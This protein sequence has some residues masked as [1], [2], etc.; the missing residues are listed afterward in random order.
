MKIKKAQRKYGNLVK[1]IA[2][3][4]A[5]PGH[6]RLS[7]EDLHAEGMLVLVRCC[8]DLP[9]GTTHFGKYFKRSLYNKIQTLYRFEKELKR[10][11]YNV[12]LDAATNLPALRE[13]G[14][15]FYA[16]VVLRLLPR[17]SSKSARL[18]ETLVFPPIGLFD[19][20]YARFLRKRTKNFRVKRS[21]IHGF[22]GMSKYDVKLAIQEVRDVQLSLS[23]G[24]KSNR[25]KPE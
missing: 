14:D 23:R 8:R 7:K 21:D 18:L 15:G 2:R 17:L 20:A 3:K 9:K 5:I 13:A 11:G 6:Y 10:R 19:Y 22:L 24:V 16:D 4:Y 1:F 25:R 12:S